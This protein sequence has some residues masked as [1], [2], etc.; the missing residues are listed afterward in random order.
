MDLIKRIQQFNAG[1]D[2]ERLA[3]KYALMRKNAFV[4]LR[5]SCHIFY[6]RWPKGALLKEA[7]LAWACGDM[8][9]ENFGSY[10]GDNRLAYFDLNDFDEAVLAPA[11]CDLLRCLTSIHIA[12]S[13]LNIPADQ[14]ET[15]CQSFLSS[16]AQALVLG[17]SR[18][19]ERDTAQGAIGDLLHSL[20]ERSRPAFLDSR[21]RR[22]GKVRQLRTD[23]G[24]ALPVSDTQRHQ[25]VHFM[26]QFAARQPDPGFYRVLDVARR[27][28]GTGSLGVDRYVILVEGKGS[29]DG[30]YLLDLKQAVPT[31]VPGGLKVQKLQPDWASEAARVVGVQHRMQAVSMAFLQAVKMGKTSYVL[32]A[33]QPSEDRLALDHLQHAP[34]RL[35]QA[36]ASMGQ[37]VA[38][39]QLRSS[40]WRGSA[41]ADALSEWAARRKWQTRLLAAAVDAAEQVSLDWSDFSE[42][43]DDGE[44]RNT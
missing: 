35:R 42:A 44:F 28:A 43:F 16:Y 5:G 20:R 10:K 14:A 23:N 11:T 31:S 2:P 41:T 38:W 37:L 8:H 36:I 33:L 19:L 39:A 13:T 21:T 7:P 6:E 32:R 1:R 9:L 12:A 3:M 24:K 34:E 29:P 17:K 4:F 18:W 27:I 30:N 40:G 15:L 22:K 25:V 26:Q